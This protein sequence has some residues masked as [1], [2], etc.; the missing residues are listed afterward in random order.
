MTWWRR[1]VGRRVLESQLDAELRDHVER[2]VADYVRAGLSEPDARRRTRLEFG[3]LDQVKDQCRD[4]RGTRMLEELVRDVRYALRVLR[5]SPGFTIAAIASLALGI[6]ANTAIFSLIDAAMLKS[7]P[8]REPERLIE[9]LTDRGRGNP[10]NAFSYPALEQFRDR[11]TTLD[12]VIASHSSRLFVVV[13]QAP[14]ELGAGQ[15]VTGNF[16]PVL[17]VPAHVGRTVLPSDDRPGAEPIAV[18]SHAYWLRRFGADPLVAGRRMT[19]DGLVFTI[20][21]VAP[22][23]FRGLHVG[24]TVDVWIPLSVEP[25]LRNP[26]WT[27]SAGYKWLQIVG[28]VRGGTTYEQ[29]RAELQTLFR[30]GV[31][32]AELALLKDPRP[33]HP[34]RTW[35]LAVEHAGA[36]LTTVRQQF[37]EPLFVL[38]AVSGF[39]LVIAC[40]NV[41]NLLLARAST[42]RQEIAVR[43]SLGAGRPR[44]MRQLLTESLLLSSAG[45]LLG[46]GV[47]YAGCRYLLAFFA[48][49]RV[50][51]TLEVGPDARVLAFTATLAIATG[52]LFGLA[53][54]W[55]TTRQAQGAS[56]MDRGRARGARDRRLLSRVLVGGQVALSVMMLVCAGLFLR[57][58]HNVRSI[59]TGFNSDGVLVVRTDASRSGLTVEAQRGAFREALTQLAAIR[60]VLTASLSWVTPIE[61]GGSMRTLGV[62]KPDGEIKEAQDVHLNWVSPDYF[63]TIRTPIRMGRDFAW[64]DTPASPKVAIVNQTFARQHFGDESPI[65]ARITLDGGSSEIVAVVGDSK[66]LELR[67]KVPPTVYFSAFQQE[68]A[69]GQFVIR[70]AGRPM[71]AAAAAREVVRRV[72]PSVAVTSVRSLAEQVDASIV[73]ERMLGVLSAGFA[74]LGLLLAA[75]GL[76]GVMSYMVASRTS[77]IGIRMALGAKPSGIS[78]MVVGEALVLTAAGV[79]A[80]IAGA[81]LLSRGLASL[82]YGLTPADPVTL[83]SVVLV[84]LLTG[85]AAAYFPGRR[86]GRLDPTVALRHE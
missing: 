36:G 44:V 47:A 2:Q 23:K 46:I 3:G 15:Y 58:L 24:R 5:K 22:P 13:D 48:T 10:F 61:G 31:V 80:G 82:L 50:P 30:T 81:L 54:A 70:T 41:A 34:A 73:R 63:A 51:V 55:R 49:T 40:V 21:G 20:V 43:L 60:G 33:D 42:R 35:R 7:L 86:A 53:P 25:V 72:A 56:L 29:A 62:L 69:S 27:S 32:E 78:R 68:H 18:L 16:F 37:S 1:L 52:L 85:L 26:S 14:P 28:R 12:G 77:E 9:L 17:G 66:Y 74:A 76:Y 45:A 6:G 57:S 11:A 71:A 39:V 8:V 83:W 75:V 64:H 65:G 4:V 84:M 67:D 19:L 38:L 59:E 79:V